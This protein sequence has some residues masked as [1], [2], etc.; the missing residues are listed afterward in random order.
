MVKP[1]VP[2]EPAKALATT[3]YQLP[4]ASAENIAVARGT[5]T[6][7]TY[8]LLLELERLGYATRQK[9]GC[10]QALTARWRLTRNY[11]LDN[12]DGLGPPDLDPLLFNDIQLGAHQ[13]GSIARRLQRLPLVENF[14]GLLGVFSSLGRFEAFQWLDQVSLDAAVRY[15]DGWVALLWSGLWESRRNIDRRMGE[16]TLHIRNLSLRERAWPALVCF[17]VTD[18]WQRELV[19]QIT[20]D[21]GY[22]D[23]VRVFCLADRT[24]SGATQPRASRGRIHQSA[25]LIDLGNWS[26]AQRLASSPWTEPGASIMGQ[27]L[28][29]V[30]EWPGLF[31]PLGEAAIGE[32]GGAQRARLALNRLAEKKFVAR[33]KAGNRYRHGLTSRGIDL[34]AQRDGVHFFHSA[35]A[36]FAEGWESRVNTRRHEDG[37]MALT[38]ACIEAGRPVAAGWRSHEHIDKKFGIF[39][40]AMILLEQSPYGPGWHYFEYELSAK[41]PSRIAAK[42][43]GYLAPRRRDH[44]PVLFVVQDDKV[45]AIFQQRG[46]VGNLPMLTTTL[47]RLKDFGPLGNA[48]CWS[49]YGQMVSVG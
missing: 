13:E 17:V 10:C 41:A 37:V 39:P 43:L 38:Q 26:L 23:Y 36:S 25:S 48:H 21:W 11:F 15:A 29:L 40:D 27:A 9:L 30:A 12:V 44:W 14:Y 46:A 24:W 22:Q 31:V 4:L 6:S 33:V 49:R 47:Q 7:N 35:Y 3:L 5:G 16:L 32:T 42:L 8:H 19:R 20:V 45:E 28:E 1:S 2:S 34:I 18:H